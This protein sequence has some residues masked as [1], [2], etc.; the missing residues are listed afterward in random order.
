[1]LGQGHIDRADER[2]ET[3]VDHAAGTIAEFLGG[4]EQRDDGAAPLARLRPAS[5]VAA[6]SR[7]VTWTSCPQACITG[8]SLPSLIGRR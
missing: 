6:P 1:M 7:Q 5:R 8:T 3:V 2:G 4:L